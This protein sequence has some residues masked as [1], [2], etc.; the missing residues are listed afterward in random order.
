MKI[1]REHYV[2]VYID[3]RNFEEFYYGK[4]KGN[5][6]NAHLKDTGES[7][8]VNRI[9]AIR[10][11]GLEPIIKVI[12][13]NLLEPEALLIEKTLIWK[14]GSRLTNKSSGHFANKFRP[15]N[16]MHLH[17][18]GFDSQNGV[19]LVNLDICEQH[20]WEDCVEFG[21]LPAGQDRKYSNKIEKLEVGDIVAVYVP[22]RKGL[23][24]YNGYVGIGRV[25]E[26][27]VRVNDFQVNGKSLKKL[28]LR[29]PNIFDN[30][31]NDKSE[32]LAKVTWIKTV[33]R[34]DAIRESNI[35]SNQNV[36]ASLKNQQETLRLLENKFDV[37]FKELGN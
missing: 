26:K 28:K 9:K 37:D 5:R 22:K 20:S 21:F 29:A 13:R 11:A 31:N 6:K 19:Y 15:Q 1:K 25:E 16:T 10:K 7:K 4:G 18:P 3:P 23:N 33:E 14:L 36:V 35:F 34:E 8:K 2:Y 12:A 30:C 32:Y 24:P 27:A 17:Y